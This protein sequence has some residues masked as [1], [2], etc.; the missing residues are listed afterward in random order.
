MAFLSSLRAVGWRTVFVGITLLLSGCLPSSCRRIESRA[1]SP[2]DSLSRRLAATVIPDTLT[3]QASITGTSEADLEYV[4]SL[5]YD[6][7]HLYAADAGAAALYVIDPDLNIVRVVRSDLFSYPYVAGAA[8]DSVVV[9]SPGRGR[10]QVVRGDEVTDI[11]EFP[12]DMPERGLLQYAHLSGSDIFLK[13]LGDD[14]VGYIGALRPDGSLRRVAYLPGPAWRRA[15]FLRSWG[16]TLVSLNGYRTFVDLV[17]PGGQLD[18]LRLT[19]FDSPMLSRL[20]LFELGQIDAPP[21]LSSAAATFGD[22]LFVLNMRPGWLQVDVFDR[23]GKLS[24][25]LTQTDPE[26]NRDYYPTD[27]AVTSV[28]DKDIVRIAVSVVRPT[29]RID[30]YDWASAASNR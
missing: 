4:R 17:L 25:I 22:R 18:T 2:A 16:D 23:Q 12:R 13:L 8:G 27:L 14:F 1:I 10:I 15:G 30:V 24:A 20:R 7:S 19:G 9:F 5:A 21:L 3:L 6:A 29:A 26:F 11:A 28:P